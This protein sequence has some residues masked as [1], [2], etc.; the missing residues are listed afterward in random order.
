MAH[1]SPNPSPSPNPDPDP[2]RNPHP[3]PNPN[4]V[5]FKLANSFDVDAPYTAYFSPESPSVFSV[6]PAAGVLPRQRSAEGE[7]FT[8]AY[9]PLEYGKA[10]MGTLIVLT[11]EMQWSYAVRGTHPKYT[12]PRGEAQVETVLD[13]TVARGLGGSPTKNFLRSNMRASQPPR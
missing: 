10:Y 9:T 3:N 7:L 1:P 8:I 13:A 12:A 11:D 5:S 4:Q 2:N 6:V